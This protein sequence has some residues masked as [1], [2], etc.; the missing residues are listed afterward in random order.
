MAALL[1]ILKDCG[2]V[3]HGP[4]HTHMVRSF[5]D[6]VVVA[7][8]NLTHRQLLSSCYQLLQSELPRGRH[9]VGSPLLLW[10]AS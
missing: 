3:A 5:V 8:C 2:D 10:P 6:L 1:T 9:L 7:V 4:D